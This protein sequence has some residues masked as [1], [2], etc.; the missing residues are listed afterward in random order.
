MKQRIINVLIMMTIFTVLP[1]LIPL[2]YHSAMP[3]EYYYEFIDFYASNVSVNDSMQYIELTR[4]LRYNM[5]GSY[6]DELFLVNSDGKVIT[7]H[8]RSGETLYEIG[9][10]NI[11]I[12]FY[13]DIPS[14]LEPGTYQWKSLVVL[15]VYEN[16]DKTIYLES[17][18]FT[19]GE[20]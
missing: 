14:G 20:E 7:T 6:V 5:H 12:G 11:P 17:N 10:E 16:I 15:H 2:A 1:I 4:N 13:F 19:I 9:D 18:L 3:P 8:V